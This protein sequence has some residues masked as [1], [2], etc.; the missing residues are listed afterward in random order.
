MSEHISIELNDLGSHPFNGELGLHAPPRRLSVCAAKGCVVQE[1]IDRAGQG[2]AISGRN[3][4]AGHCV[5]GNRGNARWQ[6]RIDDG[7]SARHRLELHNAKG[8]APRDRGEDEQIGGV[9]EWSDSM[10]LNFSEERD[11]VLK[12]CRLNLLL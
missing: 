4:D 7:R 2:L 6:I 9:K 3:G 11:P 5:E 12:A 1:T 8:L 10:I